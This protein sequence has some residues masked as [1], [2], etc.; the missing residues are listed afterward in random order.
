MV[1]SRL[2]LFIFAA[3]LCGCGIYD[4]LTNEPADQRGDVGVSDAHFDDDAD[5]SDADGSDADAPGPD[6]C[7]ECAHSCIE[8]ECVNIE[9]IFAGGQHTCAIVEDGRMACWGQNSQGQLGI[10]DSDRPFPTFIDAVQG[11]QDASAGWEHTCAIDG[12]NIAWCWGRNE[13]GQLG[14][15]STANTRH[16]PQ[17]VAVAGDVHLIAAGYSH[18]CAVHGEG[19]ISCWGAEVDGQ[20]GNGQS[21]PSVGIA[22]QVIEVFD[23][24]ST[25]S[26]LSAGWGSSGA[27]SGGIVKMWGRNDWDQLGQDESSDY[28]SD[29]V[30]VD[31]LDTD[32]P[33][34]QSFSAGW[35]HACA[36]RDG[37]EV[38]CWGDDEGGQLGRGDEP[39]LPGPVVDLPVDGSTAVDA[40]W[41][42][43]SCARSSHWLYCW[44]NNDSGQLG[45]DE[46]S[47]SAFAV[48]VFDEPVMDL[49]VGQ[50]HTCALVT[51]GELY[52]WGNNSNGQLGVGPTP[53]QSS[54]P[55]RVATPPS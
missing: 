50:S 49:A 43:H 3:A 8:D 29:P 36:V 27:I 14:A 34:A 16:D 41:G 28:E 17:A 42:S 24:S 6:N 46:P 45:T 30:E 40:G 11:V 21:G 32:G 48:Q 5:G 7:D 13:E 37:G 4:A 53:N 35:R 20:L 25:V 22:P 19:N 55:L 33:L 23:G 38:W 12:S 47:Q 44:G 54:E 15:G 9:S 52:C 1:A 26:G 18:G 10:D 2:F 31:V 51:G 39:Q